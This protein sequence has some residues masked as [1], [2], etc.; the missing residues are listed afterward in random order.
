MKIAVYSGSFNPLHTG[1]LAIMKYM[2]EKLDFDMVYLIVSPQN[3]FKDAAMALSGRE[4]FEAAKAAVN[5][6]PGLKVSVKDIELEMPAPNYT[7]RTLD[8]LKEREPDNRFILAIGADNLA[9]IRK[10]K[11]YRRLLSEYGAVV[12]PRKGYDMENIKSSLLEENPDYMIITTEAPVVDI[13]STEIRNA[14]ASGKDI[15]NFLM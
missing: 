15:E 9:S 2:T 1:H 10:W 6:H 14:I 7:I 11:D 3:P 13:S 5:R 8:A 4:R 12:Y